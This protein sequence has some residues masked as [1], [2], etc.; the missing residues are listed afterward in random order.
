M[1]D[2]VISEHLYVCVQN[3]C[4]IVKI[5]YYSKCFKSVSLID[6]FVINKYMGDTLSFYDEG[7]SHDNC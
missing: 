3:A 4:N 7:N 6:H 1:Y 5:T 2:Y